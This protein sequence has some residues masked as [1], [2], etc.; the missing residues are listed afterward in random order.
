MKG[1]PLLQGDFFLN[2]LQNQEANFYESW[3]KASLGKGNSFFFSNKGPRPVQRGDNYKKA[4]IGLG[5]FKIFFSRTVT[6]MLK[7]SN[8]HDSFLT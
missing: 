3:Y 7:G 2:L 8:L 5:H 4:K 1:D 6:T